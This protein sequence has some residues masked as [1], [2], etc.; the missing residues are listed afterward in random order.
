MASEKPHVIVVRRADFLT[1]YAPLDGELVRAYPAGKPLK[2][3][4]TQPGRSS[5][6]NRLYWSLLRLLVDNMDQELTPDILHEWFKMRLGVT[7]EVRLRSGEINTV[8][9]STAFDKLTHEE[10]TAYMGRV[11]RLVTEQ[12]IPRADSEAFVRE[13][14]LMIGEAA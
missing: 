1:P 7:H 13:A 5:P 8:T 6:Q 3:T 11:K 9:G 10:F 4:I 2:L 12:L 14:T